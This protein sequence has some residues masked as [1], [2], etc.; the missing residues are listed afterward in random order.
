M[1]CCLPTAEA[2]ARPEPQSAKQLSHAMVLRGCW[3]HLIANKS[4]LGSEELAGMGTAGVF[5]MANE[6]VEILWSAHPPWPW[7]WLMLLAA[8]ITSHH[9]AYICQVRRS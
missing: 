9:P 4:G 3:W 8:S 5:R 7:P 1:R 2:L 6:P